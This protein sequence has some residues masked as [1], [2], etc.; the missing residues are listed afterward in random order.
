MAATPIFIVGCVLGL[1]LYLLLVVVRH[2]WHVNFM[3]VLVGATGGMLAGLAAAVVVV[4]CFPTALT[5]EGIHSYSA[6]GQR[7][8][9]PWR[10]I[11]RVRP[12]TLVC[13]KYLRLD[14]GPG[15]PTTWLAMFQ[16]RGEELQKDLRT[17][18]P[19]GNP[20]LEHLH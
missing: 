13:C 9:M 14:G 3:A 15:T 5:T 12:F 16:G 6:M 11:V 2:G 1:P 19:P 8:F 10:D 4:R 17:L 18:A 7:R 20:I